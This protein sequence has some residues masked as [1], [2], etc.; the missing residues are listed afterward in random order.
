GALTAGLFLS[1]FVPE[2][3]PWA[4]LDIAGTAWSDSDTAEAGKGGTGFGVRTLL[5]LVERFSVPAA[6]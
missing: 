6:G 1:E 4:H 5:R 3:M 2:G